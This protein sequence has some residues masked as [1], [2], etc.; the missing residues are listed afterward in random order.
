MI[1]FKKGFNLIDKAHID[2]V[3]QRFLRISDA[4]EKSYYCDNFIKRR[5]SYFV[6]SYGR[7]TA[8]NTSDI[9]VMVVLPNDVKKQFDGHKGNGKSHL[10]QDI[11]ETILKTF[12]NTKIRADGQVVV[13]DF[14]D[15]MKFEVLPG[16]DQGEGAYRH[17]DT[18]DGG[19]WKLTY[20]FLEQSAMQEIN[21]QCNGLLYDTCRY[22]RYIR[23]ECFND[24]KLSGIVIDSFVFQY[25]S[26]YE[27]AD[28]KNPSNQISLCDYVQYLRNQCIKF[29]Q[30]V[31]DNLVLAPGAMDLI[32][33]EDSYECLF[34][35][36]CEWLYLEKAN[37][38]YAINSLKVTKGEPLLLNYTGETIWP[39]VL[40]F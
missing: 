13:V 20:P 6:G 10:L 37:D 7:N 28:N 11:R 32:P 25:T 2:T 31:N 5:H 21:R 29:K 16:F 19:S 34:Q 38:K 18:H 30:D 8:I 40:R 9:D 23:D 39:A 4:I 17:P 24:M 15:G 12:P 14:T 35:V 36:L 1:P 22:I 3:K 27:W 26:P 33:A